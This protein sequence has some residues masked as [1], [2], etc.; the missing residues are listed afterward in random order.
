MGVERRGESK[1]E[2]RQKK[3]GVWTNMQTQACEFEK[4]EGLRS[5]ASL[6]DLLLFRVNSI[7]KSIRMSSFRWLLFLCLLVFPGG[8]VLTTGSP[9]LWQGEQV[10]GIRTVATTEVQK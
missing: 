9:F 3:Y 6:I 2:G 10:A 5:V 8:W 4:A 1:E 7:S